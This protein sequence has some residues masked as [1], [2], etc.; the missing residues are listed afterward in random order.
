MGLASLARPELYRGHMSSWRICHTATRGAWLHSISVWGEFF[1][2]QPDFT[3]ALPQ[4]EGKALASVVS[5]ARI[6]FWGGKLTCH[7]GALRT[8]FM[9]HIRER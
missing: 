8:V 2:M 3:A 6:S 5:H 9:L 4:I 1:G 7:L